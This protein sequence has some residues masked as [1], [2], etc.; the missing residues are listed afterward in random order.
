MLTRYI[1]VAN[2]DII[3]DNLADNIVDNSEHDI[4][5]I[6]GRLCFLMPRPPEI[7]ELW[8][9][10]KK[11][12]NE[13]GIAQELSK[14]VCAC[15]DY[16]KNITGVGDVIFLIHFGGQ[17]KDPCQFL[18]VAMEEAKKT[19]EELK[20]FC[21][22]AVS[23]TEK[24]PDRYWQENGKLHIPSVPPP[25]EELSSPK[26]S[27]AT[28]DVSAP[29]VPVA[30]TPATSQRN[31]V[32]GESLRM[33]AENLIATWKKEKGEILNCDHLRG[34]A[35]L[36]QALLEQQK[37]QK[38]MYTFPGTEWFQTLWNGK[39]F[40][41]IQEAFSKDE[42]KVLDKSRLL[43]EFCSA[44]IDIKV[45]LEKYLQDEQSLRNIISEI[46]KNI[47]DINKSK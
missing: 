19:V 41:T 43:K 8:E 40:D 25:L 27:G 47:N 9:A 21:F 3:D 29:V 16:Y 17:D 38:Q 26:Q 39:H 44:F 32:S 42:Q 5:E 6:Q 37:Q 7:Q 1:Y 15:D 46:S 4:Q 20:R 35:I 34:I 33:Q 22:I 11:P 30:T 12:D 31:I 23:R 10:L 45:K 28:G 18:S 13:E 36:C 2:D 14:L 24:F